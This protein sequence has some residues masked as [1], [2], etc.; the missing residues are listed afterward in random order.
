MA[1]IEDMNKFTKKDIGV[2]VVFAGFDGGSY[3][4][5][6]SGVFGNVVNVD[7]FP[8]Y[9]QKHTAHLER[10]DWS[11]LTRFGTALFLTV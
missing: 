11:R 10:K 9:A 7:Y 1:D 2:S 8:V 6:I 3:S 5:T 4:A